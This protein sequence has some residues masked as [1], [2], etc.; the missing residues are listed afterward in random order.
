MDTS[1]RIE[2]SS[3]R[4]YFV[5]LLIV[6]FLL[7]LTI[8]WLPLATVWR[9]SGYL[10]VVVSIA[11]L[12]WR[13]VALRAGRSCISLVCGKDRS[14]S[15]KLLDGV[16]ISGEVC[17]HTLVTPWVLI[18]NIASESHGKRNLLLFPDA[19]AGEDYRR[20]LVLLRNS[21]RPQS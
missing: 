10:V 3:S 5:L 11:R 12:F 4:A 6:A 1:V 16:Q 14:I 8:S 7:I 9:W 20:F 17:A 13:D 18:L 19:M 21:E 2:L 15:L